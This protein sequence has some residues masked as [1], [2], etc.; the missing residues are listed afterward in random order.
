MASKAAIA[1]LQKEYKALLK[2]PVPHIKAHPNPSN[3]LDWHFIIEGLRGSDYEGGL[4]HGKVSSVSRSLALA[5]AKALLSVFAAG[6][7][8]TG[9]S[10]QAAWHHDVHPKWSFC[11]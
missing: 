2:E 7:I 9:L 4:Y 8:S 1:R 6:D 3:M 5:D 10:I 11:N